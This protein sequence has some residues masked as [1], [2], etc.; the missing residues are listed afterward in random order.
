MVHPLK[1][2]HK[3][4]PMKAKNKHKIILNAWNIFE[5]AHPESSTELLLEMTAQ[6]CKCGVD[7]VVEALYKGGKSPGS[8]GILEGRRADESP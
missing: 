5:E 2:A 3:I 1:S 7:D 4:H 6:H 8:E